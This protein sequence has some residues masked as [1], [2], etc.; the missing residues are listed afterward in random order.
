[1]TFIKKPRKIPTRPE[2]SSGPCAK[3]QG[4][5]SRNI[6]K[7]AHLGRSHR[8][9]NAKL[10]IKQV[11][12]LT[13]ETLNIPEDYRVGLVPASNTG[14]FEMAMWTLIGKVPVDIFAWENFGLVWAS[15]IID[16]LKIQNYKLTT[17]DY[18][19]LPDMSSIRPGSDVCFTWNGTTSGVRVPNADWIPSN[20]TGLVLCDA[21]SAV[22]GQKIDWK[23]LDATTF[24]WQKAMGGEGAHG[25][26]VLS[27]KAVDRLEEYVPERPLPK[28]FRL[29]KNGKLIEE[30]FSGETINTPS[31]FCVADALDA[32]N[33]IK[34]I[35][36]SDKTIARTNK[37]FETIQAWI[38]KQYWIEN[39]V[40]T[41]AHRSTT[42]VCLKIVAK[43][44][45]AF[46]EENQRRFVN[47]FVSLLENENVAYD[48]AGHRE[49][50]PGLRIWCGATI[51]NQDMCLLLPWLEWAFESSRLMFAKA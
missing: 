39:L 22:F 28:I 25:M 38:D 36:G 9:T 40:V 50:P 37:N 45:L 29:V 30:I 17:S 51:E 5:E 44:F 32:L 46:S 42:S 34:A 31:M 7:S 47:Y 23:K 41:E 2:F 13:K 21:T 10:Q 8:S 16:Q 27:P 14:A 1:M 12:N 18:G 4:W 3:R 43:E 48:I 33:W 24:S 35:G 26:I 15:D 6:F 11:I 20:H 49:A 19:V